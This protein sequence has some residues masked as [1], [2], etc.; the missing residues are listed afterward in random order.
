M[1]WTVATIHLFWLPHPLPF[2]AHVSL[3]ISR[4]WFWKVSRRLKEKPAVFT[5]FFILRFP[6]FSQDSHVCWPKATNTNKLFWKYKGQDTILSYILLDLQDSCHFSTCL[7]LKGICL[8]RADHHPG[9]KNNTTQQCLCQLHHQGKLCMFKIGLIH[10]LD[11]KTEIQLEA[12]FLCVVKKAVNPFSQLTSE[13][14]LWLCEL[15]RQEER[16]LGQHIGSVW[17]QEP[18]VTT[19]DPGEGR[20]LF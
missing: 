18:Y 11:M 17:S 20:Q 10:H 2:C 16:R 4:F 14:W 7:F 6:S 3:D 9:F 8:Q 1:L 15:Q 13:A 19:A 5:L 12:K